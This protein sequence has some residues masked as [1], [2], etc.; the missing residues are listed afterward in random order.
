MCSAFHHVHHS[1]TGRRRREELTDPSGRWSGDGFSLFYYVNAREFEWLRSGI[2]GI[3]SQTGGNR[4]SIASLELA[5]DGRIEMRQ[6][7]AFQPIYMRRRKLA[8]VEG[9]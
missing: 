9:I 4:K 1:T 8:A 2:V 6:D 3:M 5:R 7:E